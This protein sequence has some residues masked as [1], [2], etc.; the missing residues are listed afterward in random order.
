MTE[1]LLALCDAGWAAVDRVPDRKAHDPR[2]SVSD[3]KIRDEL[4]YAPATTLEQGL[5]ETVAW[6]REHIDWWKA[7]K[8]PG[9][10]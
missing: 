7:A 5:A 3:R 6:Y 1:R 2:Y 9:G 8:Y 4:G 10:R